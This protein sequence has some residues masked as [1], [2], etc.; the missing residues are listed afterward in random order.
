MKHAIAVGWWLSF[1]AC[2]WAANWAL[3]RW[4]IVAV[5]FGLTAP[6][7]VYFAGFALTARD[8]VRER[9]GFSAALAAVVVGA[10]LS[11][12]L[13]DLP[14][15]AIA[16]AVAFAVS[17][18]SDALVYERLRRRWA[19]AVLASGAVGLVIDSGLFLGIAF[20]SL[21]YIE[22]QIVGKVIA[23]LC[24]VGALAAYREWRR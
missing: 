18:T 12:W 6:A 13:E 2:V 10:V 22:G 21:Q 14:R 20:G 5:G 9:A 24:A 15:I 7:G 4:G 1:V 17:E 16:S 8:Q 19:S 3:G 23:T 11:W